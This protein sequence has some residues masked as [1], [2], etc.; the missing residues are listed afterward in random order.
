[1]ATTKSSTDAASEYRLSVTLNLNCCWALLG[2]CAAR[3]PSQ[4]DVAFP[5]FHHLKKSPLLFPKRRSRSIQLAF[6]VPVLR[7]EP[8]REWRALFTLSRKLS[9]LTGQQSRYIY[10]EDTRIL[11]LISQLRYEM[12]QTQTFVH[13]IRLLCI[14]DE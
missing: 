11:I 12:N 14:R 2:M 13:L 3:K 8:S 4:E 7:G 6:K 1:M 5:P 10:A 9:G